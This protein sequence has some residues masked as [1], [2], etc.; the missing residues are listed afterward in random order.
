MKKRALGLILILCLL[1]S[2]AACAE[3]RYD[4]LYSIDKGDLTYSVRG[5]GTRPRQIT[6]KR[7]D[8]LL[9]STNVK[10]AKSLGAWDDAYGLQVVDLNFDGALDIM[11]PTDKEGDCVSYVCWLKDAKGDGYTRSSALSEL[12]NVQVDAERLAIFGFAHSFLREKQPE[13]PDYTVSTD[14]TTKYVWRDGELIPQIRASISYYSLTDIYCYSVSYYDPAEKAFND[15]DDRWLT[16][17]EYGEADFG[18][19]YYFK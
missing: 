15:P 17:E 14:T 19:L 7:G 2:L 1:V 3:E 13:G 16:P 9:W 12:Y 4:L 6:V 11:I 5:S 10:V 18:F 8:D